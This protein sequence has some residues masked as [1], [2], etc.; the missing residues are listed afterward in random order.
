MLKIEICK[1]RV[2]IITL[3]VILLITQFR[4]NHKIR[5]KQKISDEKFACEN[6]DLWLYD[7]FMNF[8]ILL[9]FSAADTISSR[10]SRYS[11]S[12]V[13]AGRSSN[14]CKFMVDRML[15]RFDGTSLI[16]DSNHESFEK[17]K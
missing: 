8:S 7:C 10:T 11:A 12:N 2:Y 16:F 17:E 3:P 14:T 9:F 15:R 5:E 4:K 13:N 6:F 1:I